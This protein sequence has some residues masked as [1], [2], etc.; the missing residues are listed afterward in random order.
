MNLSRVIKIFR[1]QAGKKEIKCLKTVYGFLFVCRGT[2]F[3]LE[4]YRNYK[5]SG[6]IQAMLMEGD[7]IKCC[8][9]KKIEG[10]R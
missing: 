8:A 9:Y 2:D 5:P 1:S 10:K 3:H 6:V 4:I 7:S